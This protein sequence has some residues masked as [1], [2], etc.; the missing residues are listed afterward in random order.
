VLQSYEQLL[1]KEKLINRYINSILDLLYQTSYG[2]HNNLVYP[3]LDTF[4]EK[5]SHLCKARIEKNN[6]LVLLLPHYETVRCVQQLL[7]ELDIDA[8][9]P[10]DNGSLDIIDSSEVS[11]NPKEDFLAILKRVARTAKH[12]GKSG[13]IVISDMGLLD[14]QG[15]HAVLPQAGW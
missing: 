1:A 12:S 4:R 8:K 7:R 11:F 3:D 10:M 15:R 9:A 6:D 13:V 14:S 5:Y 2:E